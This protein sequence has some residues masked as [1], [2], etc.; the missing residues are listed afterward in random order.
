MPNQ[1]IIKILVVV[2]AE[3]ILRDH[4]PN[5]SQPVPLKNAGK[6]Y[7][8]L[9]TEWSDTDQYQ[10]TT[11]FK[12]NWVNEQD[13]EEGGY[14]LN[15]RA[16]AGDIVQWRAASLTSP[17][18]YRC[19]LKGLEYGSWVNITA[20]QSKTK[21]L[22]YTIANPGAAISGGV[23]AVQTNDYWWE[24][25]VQSSNRQAY[26]LLYTIIDNNGSNRGIFS[27]DPYIS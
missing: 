1:E 19:Y 27:H 15:V 13:Q 26:N 16:K 8:Y 22:T 11:T 18:Q 5:G 9:L 21:P 6:G 10:G 24:S 7:A 17:F 12:S 20:P 25:T 2:D 3:R 23:T 14:S 4:T